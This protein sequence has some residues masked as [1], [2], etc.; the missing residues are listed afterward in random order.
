MTE[1]GD[2]LICY[3]DGVKIPCECPRCQHPSS[4]C[5]YREGCAVL[6]AEKRAREA[7]CPK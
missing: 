7:E 4:Q 5:D 2:E 3:K 1:D 6:E